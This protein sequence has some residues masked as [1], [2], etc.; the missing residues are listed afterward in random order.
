MHTR[1]GARGLNEW[2]ARSV[3]VN[4]TTSGVVMTTYCHLSGS[5]DS[6]S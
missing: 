3:A 2:D 6:S 1:G 4:F 5:A